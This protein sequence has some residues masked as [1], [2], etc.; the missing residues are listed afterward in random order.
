MPRAARVLEVP[1]DLPGVVDPPDIGRRR[2]RRIDRGEGARRRIREHGSLLFSQVIASR[3]GTFL[4]HRFHRF[5]MPCRRRKRTV[6]KMVRSILRT[7][8]HRR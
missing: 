2:A 5:H 3:P 7:L 1:H 4:P 8:L 6:D